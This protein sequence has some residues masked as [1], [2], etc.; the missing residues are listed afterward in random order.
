MLSSVSHQL[1]LVY[2]KVKVHAPTSVVLLL[3]ITLVT[4]TLM[5]NRWGMPLAT[6]HPSGKVMVILIYVPVV[7]ACIK[8]T[9]VASFPGSL[10]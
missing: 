5:Y 8:L 6:S 2:T 7:Y 4:P 1:D 9:Q 10:V 3:T